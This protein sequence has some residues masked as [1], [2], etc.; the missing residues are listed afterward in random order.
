M[1]HEIPNGRIRG[2]K[3]NKKVISVRFRGVFTFCPAQ[4]DKTPLMPGHHLYLFS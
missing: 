2:E 4:Y 1:V 3:T